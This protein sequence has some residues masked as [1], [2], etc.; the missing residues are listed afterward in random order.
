MEWP[1]IESGR[2]PTLEGGWDFVHGVVMDCRLFVKDL[3]QVRG[4]D[5]RLEVVGSDVNLDVLHGIPDRQHDDFDGAI[6]R[7]VEQARGSSV[8]R[9]SAHASQDHFLNVAATFVLDGSVNPE[10][11]SAKY[12]A[13]AVVL[14]AID[15][16][17][18]VE[19]KYY[20][21]QNAKLVPVI[22]ALLSI[23]DWHEVACGRPDDF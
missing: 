15:D 18:V 21:E 14:V 11:P 20:I 16:K 17:I 12:L 23:K 19:L 9:R 22:K 10:S 2:S 3:A 13:H 4:W 1:R 8:T 6:A 5:R 7:V